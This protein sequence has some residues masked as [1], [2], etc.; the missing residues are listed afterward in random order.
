MLELMNKSIAVEVCRATPDANFYNKEGVTLIENG[1]IKKPDLCG[2]MFKSKSLSQTISYRVPS[3]GHEKSK[4]LYVHCRFV[5]CPN[6]DPLSLCRIGCRPGF[7]EKIERN[8]DT[9]MFHVGPLTYNEQAQGPRILV[10]SL[11]MGGAVFFLLTAVGLVIFYCKRRR[12]LKRRDTLLD[13]EE[14]LSDVERGFDQVDDIAVFEETS[15]TIE[16]PLSDETDSCTILE[17]RKLFL[18]MDLTVV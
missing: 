6:D 17:R 4:A 16:P 11:V 14:R 1:C 2:Y 13:N 8:N 9:I 3:S 15:E 12:R 7:G 5:L 18:N 10:I